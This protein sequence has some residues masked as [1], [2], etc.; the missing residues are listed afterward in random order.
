MENS[1]IVFLCALVFSALCA[2]AIFVCLLCINDWKK[3]LEKIHMFFSIVFSVAVTVFCFGSFFWFC[4]SMIDLLFLREPAKPE[5]PRISYSYE[6]E[7]EA[8]EPYWYD[9]YGFRYELVYGT[10]DEYCLDESY[11][12]ELDTPDSSAF[13]SIGYHPYGKKLWVVFRNTGNAYYY[14]DVPY[15]VWYDFKNADS[16]GSYFQECIRD[17]YEY[18]RD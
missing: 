18:E 4:Y 3:V 2:C 1:D 9:E 17:Y 10:T 7:T 8:P 16:K 12:E 15:E 13:F 6:Y 5:E 14:Y 11:E